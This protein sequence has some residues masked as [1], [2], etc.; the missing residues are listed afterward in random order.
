MLH[1]KHQRADKRVSLIFITD[2]GRDSIEKGDLETDKLSETILAG[3]SESEINELRV[4]LS[5]IAN[6]VQQTQFDSAFFEYGHHMRHQN[7]GDWNR[8]RFPW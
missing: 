7:H 8:S 3:L 4:I 2:K 6:N 5:K 1:A